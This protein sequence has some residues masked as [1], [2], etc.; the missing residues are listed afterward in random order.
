MNNKGFTLS[1]ILYPV[2]LIIITISILFL[3]IVLNTNYS[4]NRIT[5]DILAY[6]SSDL[7]SKGLKENLE[8][9]L[10][11][12]E[13]KKGYKYNAYNGGVFP[14]LVNK[15]INT[16]K[17]TGSFQTKVDGKQFAYI[18]NT[19]YCGFKLPNM[20]GVAVYN[21]GECIAKIKELTG[22]NNLPEELSVAVED[23]SI[24]NFDTSNQIPNSSTD[25]LVAIVSN[26]MANGYVIANDEPVNKSV[27]LI[28]FKINLNSDLILRNI[29]SEYPIDGVYQY[30]GTKFVQLEAYQY[31]NGQKYPLIK[32]VKS[33]VYEGQIQKYIIPKTGYY[34]LEAWGARGG[35]GGNRIGG[36]GGY[37]SGVYFFNQ[38]QEIFV[39]VGGQGTDDCMINPGCNGGFNGGGFT[40]IYQKSGSGGG[41]TSFALANDLLEN[42]SNRIDQI[43]L[44][45]GAGGGA[46]DAW[47][48][49]NSEG[50]AGGGLEGLHA[51]AN[52][53]G[54]SWNGRG[55]TQTSGGASA[56]CVVGSFGKG[57]GRPGNSIGGGGGFYGGGCGWGAGGGGGSSYISE[58]YV[59]GIAITKTGKEEMPDFENSFMVGNSGPGFAKITYLGQMFETFKFEEESAIKEHV[60][61]VP[62]TG[63]YKLEVWG[64]QGSDAPWG[65]DG[66]YGGYSVGEIVLNQGE[67]LYINVG[68]KKPNCNLNSYSD[69]GYNGGGSARGR[70]DY[71]ICPGGGATHIAKV[72]GELKTL[73]N[74]ISDILIVAGGGG[75][76]SRRWSNNSGT[77]GGSGGGYIGTF[78]KKCAGCPPRQVANQTSGGTGRAGS[79]SFGQG[80]NGNFG[81]GGGGGFYGGGSDTHEW[82]G[83]GGSGYINHSN[84]SKKHM[85]YYKGGCDDNVCVDS[86]DTS[87]K[88]IGVMTKTD[89][90]L[91]NTPKIG[92]GY[93]KITYLG[94]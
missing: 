28:W 53:N 58:T 2:F 47:P 59:Q 76:G 72:S 25:Y 14:S 70:P 80:A 62:Q 9:A 41:A 40:S 84:L 66:G 45:G 93:A 4:I 32:F 16:Y 1:T 6:I 61:T 13:T 33:F 90:A 36:K 15:T 42:L 91:E 10:V 67:K 60:Y 26:Q 22:C 34:K 48:P 77:I 37:A 75:G 78:P 39:A 65:R 57:G 8:K 64:A 44:V 51:T 74:N 71:H 83:Y 31:L 20:S 7:S 17:W 23:F 68:E 86:N 3:L 46:T 79:G 81:N 27:G 55:G 30:N 21:K 94:Q 73:S 54:T 12:S 92:H 69:G 88:S 49:I 43:L 19:K 24:I 85:N 52:P 35:N 29:Y 38:G 63:R 82:G 18:D 87:T 5:N 89:Y 50:G 11:E 56:N